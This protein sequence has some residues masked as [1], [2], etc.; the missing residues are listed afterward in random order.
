MA[1][2]DEPAPDQ[3]GHPRLVLDDQH[4]HGLDVPAFR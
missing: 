1:F 2:F 3:R 4:A